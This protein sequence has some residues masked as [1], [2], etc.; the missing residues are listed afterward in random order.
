MALEGYIGGVSSEDLINAVD[1]LYRACDVDDCERDQA[2]ID[3]AIME[4]MRAYKKG[5]LQ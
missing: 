5:F 1:Y 2:E 3:W 4:V